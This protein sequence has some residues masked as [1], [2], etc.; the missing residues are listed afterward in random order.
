[1]KTKHERIDVR[2]GAEEMNGKPAAIGDEAIAR[3][4]GGSI[5]TDEIGREKLC[6]GVGPEEP[7]YDGPGEG[8]Q[9]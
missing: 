5:V 3:V 2:E 9:E 1:M 4:T 7:A 6:P 8:R